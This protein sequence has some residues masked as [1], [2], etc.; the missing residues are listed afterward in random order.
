MKVLVK[1]V[2]VFVN[3]S[4]VSVCTI[5]TS[6]HSVYCVGPGCIHWATVGTNQPVISIKQSLL[7]GCNIT[8]DSALLFLF[9][10]ADLSENTKSIIKFAA[11]SGRCVL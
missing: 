7:L 9:R 5:H 1:Y 10:S 4:L 2:T 8:M 6:Q 3:N 11:Y